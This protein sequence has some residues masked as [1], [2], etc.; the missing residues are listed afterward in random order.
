[1]GGW[2]CVYHYVRFSDL[3]IRSSSYAVPFR[4][5]LIGLYEFNAVSHQTGLFTADLGPILFRK[6]QSFIISIVHSTPLTYQRTRDTFSSACSHS[7][8][9]WH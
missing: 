7:P 9:G 5:Y 8:H 2:S 6:V 1:M 4:L 3:R